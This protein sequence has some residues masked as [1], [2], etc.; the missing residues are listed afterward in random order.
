MFY[1]LSRDNC[2]ELSADEFAQLARGPLRCVNCGEILELTCQ[3]PL[4]PSRVVTAPLQL[5]HVTRTIRMTRDEV[6]R[7]AGRRFERGP[8]PREETPTREPLLMEDA[9]FGTVHRTDPP[10]ADDADDRPPIGEMATNGA[11]D[12]RR[13]PERPRRK[14]IFRLRPCAVCGAEFTPTGGNC[15]RCEACR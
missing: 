7:W 3:A 11:D 10:D 6:E 14:M 15:P 5:V 12:P 13:K 1:L 8:A 4:I 9:D 2:H